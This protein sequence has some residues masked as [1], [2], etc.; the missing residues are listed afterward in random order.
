M[1][2]IAAGDIFS[3]AD[4]ILKN[5][6]TIHKFIYLMSHLKQ[7]IEKLFPQFKIV[8]LLRQNQYKYTYKVRRSGNLYILKLFNLE[9]V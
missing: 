3:V 8:S 7:N 5:S 9:G 1:I 2:S 4:F 6:D